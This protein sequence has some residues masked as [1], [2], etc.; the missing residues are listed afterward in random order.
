MAKPNPNLQTP[1]NSPTPNPPPH[2]PNHDN[3]HILTR[4]L[5]LSDPSNPFRLDHVDSPAISLVLELFTSDNYAT[6]SR[7][8]HCALCAKNKLGF[9]TDPLDPLFDLWEQCNDMVV[10]LIQNSTSL[11]IKT[12]VVFADDD[13]AIWKDLEERF[14]HQNGPRIFQLKKAPSNL[15]QEH[16]SISIYHGKLKTLW[17]ELSLYDPFSACTCGTMK[18]LSDQY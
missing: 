6:W 5:N 4:Y 18:I 9:I 12:S 15:L 16:D 14:S 17:D 8:M 11:S 13:Q 7:A 1:P 3:T 2:S 10:S